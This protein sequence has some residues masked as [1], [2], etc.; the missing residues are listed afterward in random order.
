MILLEYKE[1]ADMVRSLIALSLC[2][3]CI[4]SFSQEI[5]VGSTWDI[6]EPD[7]M[8]EA[9][10]RAE[11]LP[12]ERVKPKSTFRERLAAK[13]IKRVAVAAERHYTPTH[14]V[15]REVLDR[16][17]NILYPVGF[18]YNPIKYMPRFDQRIVIIDEKDAAA[19]KP[20]LKPSDTVIVNEGDL[21]RVSQ[22]LGQRANMLDIL[23][24]EA[25]DIQRIPVVVTIDYENLAYRLEEF[26]PEFGVPL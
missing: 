4:S 15:E 25:M 8:V 17:G 1:A 2:S 11:Q 5:T 20:H 21:L 13:K 12:P 16:N 9:Q 19:V 7:P 23:T 14:T 10:R 24:A 3:V 18:T 26:M 6:V 22:L